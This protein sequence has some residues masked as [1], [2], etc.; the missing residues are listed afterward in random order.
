MEI[1]EVYAMQRVKVVVRARNE[2]IAAFLRENLR[3]VKG[4]EV[5]E[6]EHLPSADAI[7]VDSKLLSFS[8]LRVL[9]AFRKHDRITEV[10]CALCVS[11]DTVKKHLQQIYAKLGVRSVHRALL[12]ALE[13]GLLGNESGIG[14][15]PKG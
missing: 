12:R 6:P 15:Y 7:V 5:A 4:L 8:E 13:L 10:A 14:D 1:L 2:V 11:R 3:L 9:Q